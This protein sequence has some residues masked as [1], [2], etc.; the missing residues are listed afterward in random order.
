MDLFQALVKI[1]IIMADVSDKNAS[2]LVSR[3]HVLN[4]VAWATNSVL[5]LFSSLIS[6]RTK[7]YPGKGK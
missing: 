6:V 2:D 3:L 5:R 1:L 4:T 7:K